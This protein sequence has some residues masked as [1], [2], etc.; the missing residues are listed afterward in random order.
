MHCLQTDEAA[1][2]AAAPVVR[3]WSDGSVEDL[4][5][6]RENMASLLQPEGGGEC[7]KYQICPSY[8]SGTFSHLIIC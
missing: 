2:A 4:K 5:T 7:N 6:M 1:A 3:Q 8:L